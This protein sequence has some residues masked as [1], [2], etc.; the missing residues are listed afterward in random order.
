LS[1]VGGVRIDK[2]LVFMVVSGYGSGHWF[3]YIFPF[4]M[5]HTAGSFFVAV[6]FVQT[7]YLLGE[8]QGW[9][10]CFHVFDR[11][12]IVTHGHS[13]SHGGFGVVGTFYVDCH[14]KMYQHRCMADWLRIIPCYTTNLSGIR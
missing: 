12:G 7:F 1:L 11:G 14:R 3:F 9:L 8:E 2:R 13:G 6:D 4:V 10:N 5:V